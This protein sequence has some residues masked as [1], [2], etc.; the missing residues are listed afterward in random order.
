M[1]LLTTAILQEVPK[2]LGS[3]ILLLLAWFV[4]QRLTVKWSLHQKEKEYDLQ[5]ARDFHLLYGEFFAVWK[6]WNYYLRDVGQKAFPESS[7]GALLDRACLAEGKLEAIL[8]RVASNKNLAD[9]EVEALGRFRQIYQHLRESIR[10]SVPLDW[11]HAENPEY[12]AFKSYAPKINSIIVGQQKNSR[13]SRILE[14]TSNKWEH[15][16][17]SKKASSVEARYD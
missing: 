9:D 1:A 12:V 11:R 8:V 17:Q 13:Q 3:F 6:L 15:F 14:I 16:D 7:H 10:D 2:F 5:T 4:G